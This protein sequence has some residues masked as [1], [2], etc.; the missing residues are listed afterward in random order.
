MP[1]Y[2]SKCEPFTFDSLVDQFRFVIEE[3]PKN[4]SCLVYCRRI[5]SD[6]EIKTL[7]KFIVEGGISDGRS[8]F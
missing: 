3:F 5:R 4:V 7:F 1:A 8:N 2:N 6:K